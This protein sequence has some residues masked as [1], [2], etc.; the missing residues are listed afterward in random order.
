[1]HR[2]L[3]I[4]RDEATGL[5]SDEV[6][7]FVAGKK[8]VPYASDL[9]AA[10]AQARTSEAVQPDP[11]RTLPVF[12]YYADPFKSGV[13]SPS[14]ETCQCCGNATGYIYSG[15]FYSVAD[16]SHFCPWCV[17]DGSA[18]KKFDGEFN[19]SFGIGMGEIE[20]S[21]AVIGEVSRRTPSFFSFQQEQWWGHCDD[22]GQFLGEIEHLDRSLLASDTGLNFRLGIQETP[23]LST[24]ADWEWLIATPS[25]K[26]DVACF[27]FRCLHCGEMGGYIDCS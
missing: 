19:D 25:K 26:R 3:F 12:R 8:C 16:E 6:H 15:S 9:R 10:I 18:A 2:Q 27:V 14:G 13:M 20:L 7:L 17:A 24:D 4:E 21:E 11:V 5:L 23:A 22:A 1:M